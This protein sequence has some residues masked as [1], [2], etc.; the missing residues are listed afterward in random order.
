MVPSKRRLT[1]VTRTTYRLKKVDLTTTLRSLSLVYKDQDDRLNAHE[2]RKSACA[3]LKKSLTP[4]PAEEESAKSC[5][6]LVRGDF[7]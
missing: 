2:Y 5:L 1:A 6:M 3:L 7:E 4:L